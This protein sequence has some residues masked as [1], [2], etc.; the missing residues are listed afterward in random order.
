MSVAVYT[1]GIVLGGAD[2]RCAPT[3]RV[4]AL[5]LL[6][7]DRRCGG[8][9]ILLCSGF[10]S[11]TDRTPRHNCSNFLATSGWL[12]LV[13]PQHAWEEFGSE[14]DQL[15]DSKKMLTDFVRLT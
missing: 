10:S 1:A 3:F 2:S 14:D 7:M 5:E 8:V 9:R 4:L 11:S 6:G 12:E 13:R 15:R